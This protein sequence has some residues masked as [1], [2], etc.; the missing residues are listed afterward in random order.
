MHSV[1][2][3]NPAPIEACLAGAWPN[4]AERTFPYITSSILEKLV[5]TFSNVDL[6]VI[7]LFSCS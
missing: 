2:L 1:L 5:L 4:P 6:I 7:D 3:S